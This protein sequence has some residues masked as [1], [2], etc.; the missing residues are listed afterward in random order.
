MMDDRSI[1]LEA[2]ERRDPAEREEFLD[3]ACRDDIELRQRVERLLAAH[4]D[5]GSFLEQPPEGIHATVGLDSGHPAGSA[6]DW[7]ALLEPSEN[8]GCL[9]MIGPY[10]IVELIGRGGMGIVL[11]GHDPRLKRTVAIKLLSPEL[12]A[13]PMSVRRFLRE[14]Q[15]AAAVSH[16]HVVTIYAIDEHSR[17]PLLVMEYVHGKSLQQ[18]I[19]AEGAMSVTSILRIGM[20]TATGLAAAHRRERPVNRILTCRVDS[21]VARV[22]RAP[23]VG[24]PGDVGAGG[25]LAGSD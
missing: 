8:S 9:G 1:F 10:E 3:E 22:G 18:K 13:N 2:L 4:A 23:A 7:H 20:Q 17:P 25:V 11:R 14:A 19:D 12:S 24:G 5:A 16:D 6:D 21:S 15:A